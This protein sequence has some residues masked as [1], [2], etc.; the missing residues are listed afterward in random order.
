M[1]SDLWF[2]KSID[3]IHRSVL[4]I[5][6]RALVAWQRCFV[7]GAEVGPSCAVPPLPVAAMAPVNSDAYRL[8]AIYESFVEHGF[9]TIVPTGS[10]YA[11]SWI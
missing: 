11:T 2:K 9:Q 6:K 10:Q 3:V 7:Q 1:S 5:N 4:R 8:S